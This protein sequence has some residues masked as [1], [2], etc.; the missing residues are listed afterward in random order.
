MKKIYYLIPIILFS[1]GLSA[2]PILPPEIHVNEFRIFASNNWNLQLFLCNAAPN[3]VDSLKI[4]S[5]SGSSVSYNGSWNVISLGDENYLLDFTSSDL[6]PPILF[7]PSGDVITVTMFPSFFPEPIQT[8]IRYG[9]VSAPDL[10]APR[11]DQSIALEKVSSY[12]FGWIW[13]LHVYS[14]DNTPSSGPPSVY[15]TAGT[16]GVIHGKIY[17]KHNLPVANTTFFIDFAFQTDAGGN[18]STSAFSR[19]NS[20]DS[21]YYQGSYIRYA[22]IEN[23]SYSLT[24]DSVITRDIHLTDTLYTGISQK[25]AKTAA[26][27]IFPNPV[28]DKIVCSWSLDL[29]ASSSV[30]LVLTDLLGRVVQ[31]ED[32]KG[33]IGVKTIEVGLPSGT[34]LASLVSGNKI[35]STTRFMK[36]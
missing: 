33:N 31:K 28:K 24:P 9:N 29:S 4:Q 13:D 21:I 2:N 30:Q 22:Y 23:L 18:Y 8:I 3:W 35:I 16:C 14:L 12:L 27:T 20:L 26:L 10:F 11:A 19:I 1:F 32:L 25:Q 34:Y 6:T 17:D 15:D 5:L 36:N 7:N